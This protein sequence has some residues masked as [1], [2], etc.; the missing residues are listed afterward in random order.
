MKYTA[1]IS[2]KNGTAIPFQAKT[3]IKNR[4][5]LGK[6]IKFNDKSELDWWSGEYCNEIKYYI[7]SYHTVTCIY[8][9]SQCKLIRPVWKKSTLIIFFILNHAL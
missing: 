1:L 8:S 7:K 9:V 6:I 2:Q 5:E 4:D 3:G